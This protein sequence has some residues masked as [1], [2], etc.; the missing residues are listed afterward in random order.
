MP[1]LRANLPVPSNQDQGDVE[2]TSIL[3]ENGIP[4]QTSFLTY[5]DDSLIEFEG[6]EFSEYSTLYNRLTRLQS[7]VLDL[8][9]YFLD[10]NWYL[11]VCSY[12]RRDLSEGTEEVTEI[13]NIQD[14]FEAELKNPALITGDIS[15]IR[16]NGVVQEEIPRNAIIFINNKRIQIIDAF[17]DS[18]FIYQ[19]TYESLIIQRN[20]TVES[21]YEYRTSPDEETIEDRAWIQFQINDLADVRFSL[22]S[23]DNK[24]YIQFRLTFNN[25]NRTQDLHLYSVTARGLLLP[26]EVRD[27]SAGGLSATIIGVASGTILLTGE[28]EGANI[29]A[30]GVGSLIGEVSDESTSVVISATADSTTAL[31]GDA[32]T[33]I[34]SQSATATSGAVL[35]SESSATIVIV[36]DSGTSGESGLVTDA[37]ATV[38]LP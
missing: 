25:I 23:P 22:S 6:S 35:T 9:E 27:I 15:L 34:S 11:D 1:I 18:D 17:F 19:I 14:N 10:Y 21:I 36:V 37:S 32:D 4:N 29:R 12:V 8:G 31:V 5:L 3:F 13:L 16:S 38:T 7:P 30:I 26:E 24:R 2:I 20:L 28:A 33:I